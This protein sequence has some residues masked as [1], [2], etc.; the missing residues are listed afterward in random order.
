M[1]WKDQ[2]K[3]IL[4]QYEH[5]TDV[6]LDLRLRVNGGEALRLLKEMIERDDQVQ[7][8]DLHRDT[9]MAKAIHY[10]ECWDTV[11]YP[12]LSTALDEMAHHF[13]C[14][15]N[16]PEDIVR[17]TFELIEDATKAD[18]V[19]RIDLVSQSLAMGAVTMVPDFRP[20]RHSDRMT[21]DANGKPD[22]SQVYNPEVGNAIQLGLYNQGVAEANNG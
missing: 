1:N 4:H 11:A 5:R 10:P 12:T 22:Y 16:H 9:W 6:A 13:Q 20:R 21:Y 17:R 7:D 18:M 3:N 2:A 19:V 8:I 14:Q 15:E